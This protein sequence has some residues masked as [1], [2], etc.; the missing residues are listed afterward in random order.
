MMISAHSS[1]PQD[2]IRVSRLLFRFNRAE[3]TDSGQKYIKS[4]LNLV[5][6]DIAF[7]M[8]H[9][10]HFPTY[11]SRIS[12]YSFVCQRRG[13]TQYFLCLLVS[14]K[15]RIVNAASKKSDDMHDQQVLRRVPDSRS[16]PQ[17]LSHSTTGECRV[18]P[19][20]WETNR[21]PECLMWESLVRVQSALARSCGD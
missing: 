18:S 9:G 7:H 3:T 20:D 12:C 17:F 13:K 15:K 2:M 16:P 19:S 4:G 14:H 10:Q 8:R 5:G 21:P 11:D 6:E 1:Q